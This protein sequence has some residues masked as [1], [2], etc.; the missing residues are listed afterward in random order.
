[1]TPNEQQDELIR[2]LDGTYLVDAGAGT[3]K[4]FTITRRYAHILDATDAAPDDIL[5]TTFTENAAENMK[6]R[7]IDHCSYDLA[8]LRDAP[9][10]TFHGHCHDLL[11]RHGT[12]APS[13][14][15]LD[16]A[17]PPSIDIIDEDYLEQ[18]EFERF[19]RRFRQ[20]NDRYDDLYRIVD[21]PSDLLELVR[22]LASKGIVPTTDGWYRETGQH[23][24]G[25]SDAFQELFDAMNEPKDGANG[26]TNSELKNRLSS[27]DDKL[28]PPE[29][30]DKAELRANDNTV[31]EHFADEAFHD[32]REELKRFVHDV[33]LGYMRHALRNGF[34]TFQ[35]LQLFA[36]VLL[37]EDD[38][39][40]EQEGF[41]YVMLD[42]FQDTNEIQ[43][44]LALLLAQ[45][46]NLA[47]VGD[48]KQSIFGFQYA[49]VDNILRFE[50]RLERYADELNSDRQRV[51]EPGD[52]EKLS[53]TRNYRSGQAILDL[54]EHALTLEATYTE[55]LDTDTILDD[56]TSLDADEDEP[57]AVEAF[58][59]EDEQEAV[60]ARI[61]RLVEDG[62]Y[63]Y[64]DVAVL[65]RNR[66]FG[67]EL[68]ELAREY[69]VPAAFEGGVELFRTD[70]GKLLLAWCRILGWGDPRRGWA[71]VLDEVGGYS[72]EQVRA[73]LDR[74]KYPSDM[75]QFREELD[76][77][78]SLAAVAEHV[79]ARY[80]LDNG[81]TAAIVDVLH[82]LEQ[83]GQDPG[84]VVRFIEDC[85]EQG[86]TFDVDGSQDG[87]AV[88]VQTIHKAKGLEYPVVFVADINQRRLPS[89]R[90]GS[91][92]IQFREP[93]G[94]RQ[95]VEWRDEPE[96][97]VYTNWRTELV[98]KVLAGGYDEERRLLYVAMT[99]AEDR[100][101]LS[102]EE[103]SA[104]RFFDGLPLEAEQL[105][106]EPEQ[107]DVRDDG[108]PELEPATAD[109]HAPLTLPVHALVD[110][111]AM[112][113]TGGKGPEFGTQV[114]AYAEAVVDGDAGEPGNEDER[115][116]RA[117]V[118]ALGGG[119]RTEVPVMLPLEAD[120]KLT[121]S[122]TI[123]LLVEQEET[124]T[125]VDFKTDRSRANR[126][127]YRKQLSAYIHAVR[128]VFPEKEVEAVLFWTDDGEE[129]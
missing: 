31:P 115:N 74:E 81:F 35:F 42:E 9:I 4:T 63:G 90:S 78:D 22:E 45:D 18:Q 101:F 41:R 24:D 92:P 27:Y 112:E 97:Y 89:T 108:L 129:D 99:R 72:I 106:V 58:T 82:R 86:T 73:W 52:V 30:P 37:V 26:P 114:H 64:G 60:L 118:E 85:I 122:G 43:F 1:M 12:E 17:I 61:Q 121:L 119:L 120:R 111:D 14:L 56:I 76:E 50:Q 51:P 3:G 100:L 75:R 93:A 8:A 70:P 48:W 113:A 47:A 54:A 6:E 68:A 29:A 44:K 59:A 32:D 62:D 34:L 103:G 109:R 57:G 13:L 107:V 10:A 7:I 80:G 104:S 55:D 66:A 11:D 67:R 126:D 53:L 79:F 116:V 125:I 94:L 83:D 65:A 49:S 36:Y 15:G 127:E 88:T 124:V 38:G 20:E 25:D 91:K 117:F 23:L 19:Y 2:A 96:P 40:R 5:L 128:E 123:D 77:L 46:G 105:D 84:T 21:D 39:L 110:D 95:R 28:Y 69:G 71:V 98:N 87:A 16:E 102:A 33:Y